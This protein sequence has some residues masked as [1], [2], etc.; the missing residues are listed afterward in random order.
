MKSPSWTVT[1]ASFCGA[2]SY[3]AVD[4]LTEADFL[5]LHIGARSPRNGRQG[6]IENHVHVDVFQR[7]SKGRQKLAGQ[8][9]EEQTP[10]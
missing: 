3:R 1:D 10:H 5:D 4:R 9:I 6:A 7:R 8:R 2:V